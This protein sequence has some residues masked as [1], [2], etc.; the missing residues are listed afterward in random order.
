MVNGVYL[1]YTVCRFSTFLE[2]HSP[3]HAYTHIHTVMVPYTGARCLA[4]GHFIQ[5]MDA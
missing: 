2:G 5:H 1:P 4:Q 3:F